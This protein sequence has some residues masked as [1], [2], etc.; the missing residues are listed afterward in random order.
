MENHAGKVINS[1]GPAIYQ[2][3]RLLPFA[4]RRTPRP[5]ARTVSPASRSAGREM[6]RGGSIHCNA[7]CWPPWSIRCSVRAWATTRCWPWAKSP[8][9]RAGRASPA[10]TGSRSSSV[11]RS[12]SGH[13]V[14]H[15]RPARRGRT[16]RSRCRA[17]V[18]SSGRVDRAGRLSF[19]ARRIPDDD[20]GAVA[21]AFWKAAQLALDTL[22]Y[23]S[24]SLELADVRARLVLASILEGSLARARGELEA[25]RHAPSDRRRH[26]GRP[27]G[28]VCR[29][30]RA[31]DPRRRKPG[32]PGKRPT[33]GRRLPATRRATRSPDK[34]STSAP[35]F[36]R[37][38]CSASR[39]WP[40]LPTHKNSV[41]I[42]SAS[43]ATACS[44]TIR[45]FPATCCWFARAASLCFRPAH[46]QTGL[47]R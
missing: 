9:K 15:G 11:R 28:T 13:G 25:L 14:Q 6:V 29:C 7:R 10:A 17:Q 8:S 3:G 1:G 34:R 5:G 21:G 23:P 45:P 33:T 31:P 44:A 40:T 12:V 42:A 30:A 24:T 37:R 47:A 38:S 19:A 35:N 39:S 22:A 43:A 41:R 18:V 2:P 36:G 4:N 46:R 32:P 27:P 16:R 20:D 26:T